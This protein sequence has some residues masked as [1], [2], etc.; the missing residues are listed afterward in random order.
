MADMLSLHGG[1]YFIVSWP[2]VLTAGLASPAARLHDERYDAPED[3]DGS[4]P[5]LFMT[6]PLMLLRY[7][8]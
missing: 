3:V 1:Y 4:G 2:T 8:I 7:F 5:T 6:Q